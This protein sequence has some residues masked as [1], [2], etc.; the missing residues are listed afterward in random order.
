MCNKIRLKQWI[1]S[2]PLC[3]VWLLSACSAAAPNTDNSAV[4]NGQT[5]NL[6]LAAQYNVQ[7]GVSYLQQ[8]DTTL[9]KQKLILATEQDPNSVAA[10]NGMAYFMQTTDNN[11]EAQKAYQKALAIDPNAGDTLNNYGVFLCQQG[12]ARTA[13]T[14]FQKAVSDSHYANTAQAYE[15][16]GLCALKVPDTRQAEQFFIKALDNDSKLPTSCLAL[17]TLAFNKGDID[18]AQYYL[19]RYNQLARPSADSLWLTVELAKRQGNQALAR[20]AGE[21]LATDFPHSSQYQ[22]YLKQGTSS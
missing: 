7:L 12:Q 16:A 4:K 17:S 1:Q 3:V 18:R 10:W 14:Y 20:D 6:K 11:I 22:Q 13:V 8:G 2:L 5:P 21:K 15:N 19:N 9:A